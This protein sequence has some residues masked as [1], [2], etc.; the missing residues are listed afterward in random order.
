[1]LM[2]EWEIPQIVRAA[3]V[4]HFHATGGIMQITS[5]LLWA[6]MRSSKT[7]TTGPDFTAE[8]DNELIGKVYAAT[9]D[10]HVAE[11]KRAFGWFAKS[12]APVRQFCEKHGLNAYQF[13]A[14]AAFYMEGAVVDRRVYFD[15]AD[16]IIGTLLQHRMQ[17]I[18]K[19]PLELTVE[20]FKL[21]HTQIPMLNEM[22]RKIVT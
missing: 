7:L 6:A 21:F 22:R 2:D 8:P 10:K 18:G 14:T 5:P 16:Q 15:R 9:F 19:M 11:G 1:M 12:N 13:V 3:M 17:S 4:L 20:G